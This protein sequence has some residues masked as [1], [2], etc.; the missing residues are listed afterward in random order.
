ME[1]TGI[2]PEPEEREE[3][4]HKLTL[5]LISTIGNE[6]VRVNMRGLIVLDKGLRSPSSIDYRMVLTSTHSLRLLLC[7]YVCQ[8]AKNNQNSIVSDSFSEQIPGVEGVSLEE[9]PP[10]DNI[11]ITSWEQRY[12]TILPH[13]IKDFYLATDG[14]KLTWNYNHAGDTIYLSLIHI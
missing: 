9:S 1:E 14:F 6:E 13:E 5:G 7:L 8:I 4:R 3:F 12:S 10:C 2:T 11:A